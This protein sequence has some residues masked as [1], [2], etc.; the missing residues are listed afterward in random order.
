MPYQKILVALERSSQA[1]DIFEQALE[2]A[3]CMNARLM[4]FH[5]IQFSQL[6]QDSSFLG[7]GTLG[8]L[9][10]YHH[11]HELQHESLSKDLK[12]TKSW[13]EEF[14]QQA[15]SRG[16]AADVECRV[17]KAARWI[18]DL[19]Q[20]WQADLILVGRRGHKGLTELLLGSISNEVLHHAPCS[21]LVIQGTL[22]NA[23]PEVA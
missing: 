15:V 21:V 18:C 13:L 22:V 4:I 9:N 12:Q 5:S 14:Q 6:S 3:Q 11:H 17:G 20:N 7:I 8:D 1:Q 10:M 23:V 16:V 19:A 2:F